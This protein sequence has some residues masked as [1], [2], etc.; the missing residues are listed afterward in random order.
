MPTGEFKEI[1]CE[2]VHIQKV[3]FSEYGGEAGSLQS[4]IDEGEKFLLSYRDYFVEDD[5]YGVD[6]KKRIGKPQNSESLFGIDGTF[7][8]LRID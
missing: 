6:E 1:I 5:K 8:Q 7:R 2:N 4:L 3:K